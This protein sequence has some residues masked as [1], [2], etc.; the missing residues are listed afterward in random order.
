MR[1]YLDAAQPDDDGETWSETEDEGPL[2]EAGLPQI[3]DYGLEWAK[4][5]TNH[6][7]GTV[8]YVHVLS[9]GGPHDEFQVTF[10]PD[11]GKVD[12]WKFVYLPWF[13]R[14]ELGSNPYDLSDSYEEGEKLA[15]TVVDFYEQFYGE[16][17]QMEQDQ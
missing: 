7:E 14:V 8:T 10:D 3:Y 17:V 4:H 2:Y 5:T 16:L 6:R 1:T 15:E 12:D 11:S 13:D 9:T